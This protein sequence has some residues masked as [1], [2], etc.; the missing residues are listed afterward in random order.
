MPDQ[1]L[2]FSFTVKA[3]KE[4][5]HL[6][7]KVVG[8]KNAS[9]VNISTFHSF[10]RK[11]LRQDIAA[12]GRG[13]TPSFKELN[14]KGQRRVINYIQ[15]HQFDNT[16]EILNFIA[17]CKVMDIPPSEAGNYAPNPDMSQAYVEIYEKYEKHLETDGAIDYTSQQLFTDAL[18]RDVPEVKDEWQ[19]K[20][21]L[22]FVDEYQD[23]DPI[24]Y[25]IIKVLAEK[26][27][28]LRVVGDDDQG[29]YGFRGA[30]IQNILN[31]EK[32]YPD[33]KVI[34]LEQN[35]RS[36]QQIVKASRAIADFNPDRREKELFTTN[37][38]G[39]KVKHLHCVDQETEAG[40]IA[41]FISRATQ[42]VWSF[43][44]FAIL[45]RTSRQA[46]AFKEAFKASGIPF[47]VVGEFT[48][49]PEDV[50]SIM[51][52]H[53]SK[54]LEFPNVFVA[55]V[56]TGLLPHYH[57]NK[58]KWDEEL[59]LLYVAMTRAKNWLCL[60]SYDSDEFQHECGKSQFLDYIPE[61]LLENVETLGHTP[62]PPIPE[63]I[64]VPVVPEES[65]EYLEPLPIGSD[66]TVIGVDSGTLNVG[67]SI[68]Q[69]SSD[70]YT[71]HAYNTEEPVGNLEARH[72]YIK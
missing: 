11:V 66:I 44:D 51:T 43:R 68:T 25:R 42:E 15:H 4:L 58:K 23:T 69:K 22:I 21:K 36:T 5:K 37:A 62:I 70:G 72:K 33:A 48:D 18:F 65:P 60:S 41:D 17:K 52:I 64:V 16:E 59:R 6:V 67:W 7:T 2:A 63:E 47:H 46:T 10:C 34:A 19:E 53:K 26:H 39:D 35:Y 57:A 54:G 20:F 38:E 45:C 24:Q 40:T 14:A 49:T 28:N 29:I 1:I 3:S 32:D 12:L 8:Q 9:L 55:G 13:Y 27:Q 56:C 61:R 50:V 31:F 71:V 30:D